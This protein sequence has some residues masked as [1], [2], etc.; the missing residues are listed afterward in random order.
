MRSAWTGLAWRVV[1][2][3]WRRRG[4]V[5]ALLCLSPN[6]IALE[7]REAL[8]PQRSEVLEPLV[9]V[10]EWF[11]PQRIEALL[12]TRVDVHQTGVA[13]HAQVL[14]DLRLIELES[15]A[16]R[17]DGLRSAAQELDDAEAVRFGECGESLKHGLYMHT[18]VYTCQVIDWCQ[19]VESG[20]DGIPAARRPLAFEMNTKGW[21]SQM[22]NI[23]KYLTA[24]A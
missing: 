18:C 8:I 7:V 17:P 5:D 21:G 6:E 2:G 23:E 1:R 9:E 3:R 16:D 14:R 10:A 20:F 24:N 13:Q 19:V 22:L 12:R 15:C 11:G 4:G